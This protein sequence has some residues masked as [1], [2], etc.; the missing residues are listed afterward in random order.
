MHYTFIICGVNYFDK[1]LNNV[2]LFY[3]EGL[4][5]MCQPLVY[6]KSCQSFIKVSIIRSTK[7]FC[8]CEFYKDRFPSCCW[9]CSFPIGGKNSQ[10][11]GHPV[12]MSL[13]ARMLFLHKWLY[14]P[15]PRNILS[16]RQH[17]NYI[18]SI[19]SLQ[20]CYLGSSCYVFNMKFGKK[21]S[22]GSGEHLHFTTLS[23]SCIRSTLS[24]CM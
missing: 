19:L 24:E 2:D 7:P 6:A 23:L 12:S 18:K 1:S 14:L 13:G 17:N 16:P 5:H 11:F 20:K 21:R 9:H 22:L 15:L 8:C 4:L 3:S 10:N